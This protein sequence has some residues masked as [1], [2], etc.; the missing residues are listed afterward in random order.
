MIFSR[1]QLDQLAKSNGYSINKLISS[2][3][4]LVELKA[5]KII[6]QK[7]IKDV[8]SS[9]DD[10]LPGGSSL[11][12]GTINTKLLTS[13]GY[14]SIQKLIDDFEDNDSAIVEIQKTV[15][16]E[17]KKIKASLSILKDVDITR[18]MRDQV[19]QEVLLDSDLAEVKN[20]SQEILLMLS[21][22]KAGSE[23]IKT[24]MK[25]TEA[26]EAKLLEFIKAGKLQETM[27]NKKA[28][29]QIDS[30]NNSSVSLLEKLSKLGGDNEPGTF[31]ERLNNG[32]SSLSNGK[33]NGI[34]AGTFI[35]FL[36]LGL[37]G[38]KD[39]P[40]RKEGEDDGRN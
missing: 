30:L 6:L 2:R 25:H 1:L 17:D 13:L 28:N 38:G 14:G 29:E 18:D 37:L 4:R 10:I 35:A 22:S 8:L 21:Q 27:L 24:A 39:T 9:S 40:K 36:G 5:E 32:I 19:T 11:L 20:N 7:N 33:K 26:N 3:K 16:E 15:V 34:I 31:I 12:M 23:I